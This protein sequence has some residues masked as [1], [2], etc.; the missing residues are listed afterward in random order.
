MTIT[1]W[2]EN[3]EDNR[4]NPHRNVLLKYSIQRMREI[5][6]SPAI[7][8]S[9]FFWDPFDATWNAAHQ[10][11]AHHFHIDDRTVTHWSYADDSN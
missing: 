9:I 4:P 10:V 7:Y 6:P 1:D 11:A 3:R 2:H 5:K 8:D